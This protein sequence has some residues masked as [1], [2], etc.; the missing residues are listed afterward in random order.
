M[1][2]TKSEALIQP[3]RV[4]VDGYRHWLTVHAGGLTIHPRPGGGRLVSWSEVL[5]LADGPPVDRFGVVVDGRLL[6]I[7]EDEQSA[8]DRAAEQRRLGSEAAVIRVP[9][10]VLR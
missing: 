1:P 3:V 8:N 4:V 9:T 2:R 6:T 7:I 5:R 10:P